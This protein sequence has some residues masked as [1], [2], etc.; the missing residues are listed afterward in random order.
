MTSPL[1]R[2]LRETVRLGGD[3]VSLVMPFTSSIFI[4]VDFM[5]LVF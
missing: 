3:I 4:Y 5:I 2:F 1:K